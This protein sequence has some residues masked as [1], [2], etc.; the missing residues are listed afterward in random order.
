VQH[1]FFTADDQSVSGIVTTLETYHALG[2]VGQPVNDF[3]FTFIAPLG[4]DDYNVFAHNDNFRANAFRRIMGD[5]WGL[6]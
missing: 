6:R 5:C 1:G 4:A 3:S 2:M